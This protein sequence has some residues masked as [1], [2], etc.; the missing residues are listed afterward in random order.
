MQASIFPI[1]GWL[2]HATRQEKGEKKKTLCTQI[3]QEK[4]II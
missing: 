3:A 2:A 1:L 4:Q